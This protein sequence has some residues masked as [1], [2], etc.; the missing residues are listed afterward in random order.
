MN[1]QVVIDV[2]EQINLP[3]VKYLWITVKTFMAV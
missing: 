3:N 2:K 1:T